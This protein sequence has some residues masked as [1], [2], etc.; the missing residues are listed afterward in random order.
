MVSGGLLLAGAKTTMLSQTPLDRAPPIAELI[1]RAW[2]CGRKLLPIWCRCLCGEKR[3][4][5]ELKWC[6]DRK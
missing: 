2:C 6:H 3:R 4:R 1:A 5:T